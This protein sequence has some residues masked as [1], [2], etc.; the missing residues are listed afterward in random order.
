MTS[1]EE[2]AAVYKQINDLQHGHKCIYC[3][4]ELKCFQLYYAGLMHNP[5][6]TKLIG[7][8]K[9]VELFRRMEISLYC[10][11]ACGYK[12]CPSPMTFDQFTSRPWQPLDTCKVCSPPSNEVNNP[13]TPPE[14]R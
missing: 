3:G 1:P 8:I 7:W 12:H 4:K 13:S 9:G 10:C 2:E 11:A 14:Q 5:F 6:P